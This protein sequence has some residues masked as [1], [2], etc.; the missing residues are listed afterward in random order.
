MSRK[1]KNENQ[2]KLIK[3]END[4]N[5]FVT[6]LWICE[7]FAKKRFIYEQWYEIRIFFTYISF[8]LIYQLNLFTHYN[9]Y[10]SFYILYH[11]ITS[12]YRYT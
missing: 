9:V 1:S 2:C 11:L 10:T 7:K 6:C 4:S 12:F 8:K 3:V 5:V